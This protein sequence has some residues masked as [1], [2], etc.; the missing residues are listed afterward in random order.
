MVRGNGPSFRAF[1]TELRHGDHRRNRPF[2]HFDNQGVGKAF[3]H[4]DIGNPSVLKQAFLDGVGVD[5]QKRGVVG[6]RRKLG[7]L[8][9]REMV[10]TF[11]LDIRDGEQA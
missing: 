1:P 6:D 11:D 10:N 9:F 3:G 4:L 2:L 7:H 8:G 5:A